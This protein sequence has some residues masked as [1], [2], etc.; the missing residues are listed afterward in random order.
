[1]AVFLSP[2][3]NDAPYMVNGVAATGYKLFTYTAGT[4]T[5]QTTYT[6]STGNVANPNPIILNSAGY[7]PNEIWL[8]SGVSYKFVLAPSNDTDPP[9]SPIWTRDN[10]SAIN[11]ASSLSTPNEWVSGPTPTYISATSF[12][13]AGDQTSTFNVGRRVKTTNSGGTIYSTITSSVFGAVTTIKLLNDSGSLDSGLSAVSYGLLSASNPSYPEVGF[14]VVNVK[15][16]TYNAVGDGVTDDTSAIQTAINSLTNGGVVFFPPGIYKLA[17]Q[18]TIPQNIPIILRGS[19]IP[20][21]ASS[22]ATG[23]ELRSTLRDGTSPALKASY[24]SSDFSLFS[25]EDLYLSGGTYTEVT[26]GPGQGGAALGN[27]VGLSIKNRYRWQLRN[28]RIAGFDTDNF[29]LESAFYGAAYSSSFMWGG[30]GVNCIDSPNLDGFYNCHFQY[31][32]FGTKNVRHTYDCAWEGNWKSGAY[33]NIINMR[34]D[35][36]SPH[37]ESN[38]GS[39]TALESDIYSDTTNYL[40]ALS[41]HDP[42]FNSGSSYSAKGVATHNFYG[43]CQRLTVYGNLFVTNASP[44]VYALFNLQGSS[45]MYDFSS[46]A[47]NF[48]NYVTFTA[49]SGQYFRIPDAYLDVTLAG[50]TLTHFGNNSIR[51]T[52]GGAINLDNLSSGYFGQKVMLIFADAN[53]TVRHVGG[54]TGNIRLAGGVNFG[55]TVRDTMI[56]TYDPN[57]DLWLEVSRAAVN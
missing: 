34:V 46:F 9:V 17:S 54:G 35:H 38:N 49:G 5:K 1:L 56:L 45:S 15:Y 16:P 14:N 36:Y 13:L 52:A 55:G 23:T 33:Y 39:N 22:V 44:Q 48:T 40:A 37:F 32:V 41:L 6:T 11:D 28:V 4:T 10:I 27:F 30:C 21:Q 51:L 20:Q 12:S 42:T 53:I 18:L 19:G 57:G 31:N 47:G 7:S 3:F 26:G 25:M 24:T 2:I 43:K 8:T 50:A 29:R